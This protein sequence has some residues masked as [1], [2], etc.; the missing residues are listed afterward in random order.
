[1]GYP[2]IHLPP[3][4][5]TQQLLCPS[6]SSPSLLRPHCAIQHT[7]KI[8][9]N[10]VPAIGVAQG[11]FDIRPPLVIHLHSISLTGTRNVKSY[12]SRYRTL[13][14]RYGRTYIRRTPTNIV[15]IHCLFGRESHGF[16]SA[17][18]LTNSASA[19]PRRLPRSNHLLPPH[20]NCC[21][22]PLLR[23][24]HQIDSRPFLQPPRTHPISF[25]L[26]SWSISFPSPP[27]PP[28]IGCLDPYPSIED[29]IVPF[30]CKAPQRTT[31]W[32]GSSND[33]EM[34]FPWCVPIRKLVIFLVLLLTMHASPC[35]TVISGPDYLRRITANLAFRWCST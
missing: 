19:H 34:F 21:I 9:Q 17:G 18:I 28:Q 4:Q 33:R 20:P 12:T 24:D 3:Q 26:A 32:K 10:I 6:S 23:S 31:S 2:S 25:S 8:P 15:S 29:A 35:E 22:F 30:G 13:W 16:V 14:A 11:L 7:E 1:M 5:T 27:I